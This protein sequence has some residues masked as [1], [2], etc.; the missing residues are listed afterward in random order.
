MSG[1]QGDREC[2]CWEVARVDRWVSAWV[3]GKGE[4][5]QGHRGLV[6]SG[7]ERWEVRAGGQGLGLGKGE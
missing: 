5:G 4:S 1:G 2:V 7:V 3:G 6:V